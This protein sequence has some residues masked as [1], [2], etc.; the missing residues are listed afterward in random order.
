MLVFLEHA[1]EIQTYSQKE[2]KDHV[3]HYFHENREKETFKHPVED[4]E[5]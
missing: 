2:T 1:T 5:A 3:R 4:T